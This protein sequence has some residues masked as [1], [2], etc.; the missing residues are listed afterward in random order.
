[1]LQSYKVFTAPNVIIILNPWDKLFIKWF[2]VDCQEVL[3]YKVIGGWLDIV[4]EDKF[5]GLGRVRL[6]GLP[7]YVE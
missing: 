2:S 6:Q 1:M 4:G 5:L 3:S 7:P